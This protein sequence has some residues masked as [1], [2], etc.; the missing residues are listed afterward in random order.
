MIRLLLIEDENDSAQLILSFFK[1]KGLD[2][3]RASKLEEARE[4]LE[5]F[6]P[7]FVLLDLNLPDGSGFE[8]IPYL[9]DRFPDCEVVINSAY[10][11]DE[12]KNKA[13]SLGVASFISKPLNFSRLSDA[14]GV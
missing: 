1:R 7:D 6:S 12:E 4:L 9:K 2:V 5:I 10:D 3:Q 11:T 8:F 14:L 13:K